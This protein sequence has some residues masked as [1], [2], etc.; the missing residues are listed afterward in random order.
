MTVAATTIA[1]GHREAPQVLVL[2]GASAVTAV[3][4]A[5]SA[6]TTAKAK[7]TFLMTSS[8]SS[9]PRA[10]SA[11]RVGA[12]E[13]PPPRG[14]GGLGQPRHHLPSGAVPLV[15][16]IQPGAVALYVEVL[17]VFRP[18]HGVSHRQ[19]ATTLSLRYG[20]VNLAADRR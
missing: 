20:G 9:P 7:P 19:G 12:Q 5:S 14:R 17:P 3:V 2:L 15:P 8:I 16:F 13:H 10:P 18:T 11:E 6:T 4:I 1:N